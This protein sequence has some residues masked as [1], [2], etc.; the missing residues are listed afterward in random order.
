MNVKLK[1]NILNDIE[2]IRQKRTISNEIEKK[3]KN[4]IIANGTIAI[5]MIILVLIFTIS[6]RF[7]PKVRTELIY[8]SY[9][10][11]FLV[12]S[13]I[14]FEI[15]YKKDS[16][17]LAIYGIEILVLALFTLFAPNILFKCTNNIICAIIILIMIYY[18][19]KMVKIYCSEK[20]KYILESSDISNIIKKESQDE[21]AQEEKWL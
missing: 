6:A 11:E 9:A 14:I 7:L 21:K 13:L 4:M 15:G 17:K 19:T 20:K 16:G 12:L 18:S 10:I 1:K 2:N 8:K 3:I 5:A